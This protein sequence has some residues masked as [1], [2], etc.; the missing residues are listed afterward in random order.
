LKKSKF[1]ARD[2]VDA[3]EALKA[4][5][6]A[7]TICATWGI[8]AAT[9]SAW[10]KNYTG[11][12]LAGVEKLDQLARDNTGLQRRVTVLELNIKILQAALHLQA[13]QA[14]QKRALID[15][16]RERF[17]VSVARMSQLLGMSRS[18]YA[19]QPVRATLPRGRL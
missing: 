13:L 2:R 1:S 10:E 4:G 11:Q 12:S 16:L 3:L 17:Q 15:V 14:D 7:A 18:F 9:L 5:T 19:Y 8:S 6:S